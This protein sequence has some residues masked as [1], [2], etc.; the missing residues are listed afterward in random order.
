MIDV[1]EV[2]DTKVGEEAVLL[3]RQGEAEIRADE[4]AS[5]AGTIHYEIFCGLGPRVPRHFHGG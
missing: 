3:G 2:A 4:L 1:T 5:W